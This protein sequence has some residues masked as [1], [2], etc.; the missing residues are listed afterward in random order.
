M[1]KT[2]AKV[3]LML[4]W[5]QMDVIEYYRYCSKYD[6]DLDLIPDLTEGR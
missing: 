5:K 2:I 4:T 1:R 6:I 3:I